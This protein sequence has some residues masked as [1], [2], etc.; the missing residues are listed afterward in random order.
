MLGG[1][2]PAETYALNAPF[3]SDEEIFS[4]GSK[5]VVART[6]PNSAVAQLFFSA[7]LPLID[8]CAGHTKLHVASYALCAMRYALC[9]R[10]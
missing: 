3:G 5:V 7:V 2:Q 8:L 10:R 6:V 9:I 4:T 1:L